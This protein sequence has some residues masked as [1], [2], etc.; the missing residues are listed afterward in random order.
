MISREA[1][2]MADRNA[3]IYPNV[4]WPILAS[5]SY[6]DTS[7]QYGKSSLVSLLMGMKDFLMLK[8]DFGKKRQPRFPTTLSL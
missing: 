1:N 4:P 7:W 6:F 2:K 8:W 5:F 3:T